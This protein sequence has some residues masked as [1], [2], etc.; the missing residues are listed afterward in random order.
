V[1]G[2]FF[3]RLLW[4]AFV[5]TALILGL[6]LLVFFNLLVF[7]ARV[8][9]LLAL[10]AFDRIMGRRRKRT[11]QGWER[12][13]FLHELMTSLEPDFIKQMRRDTLLQEPSHVRKARRIVLEGQMKEAKHNKKAI[14][15]TIRVYMEKRERG[16]SMVASDISDDAVRAVE[17]ATGVD[18]R[19]VAKGG[20]GSGT[21]GTRGS[22]KGMNAMI[23]RVREKDGALRIMFE[24][25]NERWI[26][27]SR[28]VEAPRL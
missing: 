23:V 26:A 10:L 28:F 1:I 2:Y 7:L 16:E 8:I 6:A 27:P 15:E 25:G 3:G 9:I 18:I 17:I 11:L 22:Y 12:P 5:G 14:E 19:E 4:L 24:D 20:S 13:Q 21:V